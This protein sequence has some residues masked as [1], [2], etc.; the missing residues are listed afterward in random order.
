MAPLSGEASR[1]RTNSVQASRRLWTVKAQALAEPGRLL[2]VHGGG[3]GHFSGAAGRVEQARAAVVH[4]AGAHRGLSQGRVR[5][6][7]HRQEGCR[8]RGQF[9]QLA[10][11]GPR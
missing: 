7:Q 5:G 6:G 11:C 8:G 4:H 2:R 1:A 9:A 10:A 3:H